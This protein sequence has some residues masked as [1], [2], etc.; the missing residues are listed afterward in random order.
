[1]TELFKIGSGPWEKLFEGN[2]QKYSLQLLSN[3]ESTILVAIFDSDNDK[4]RGVITEF[5]KI[6]SALG[7]IETFSETLPRELLVLTKHDSSKT[8]KFLAIGS[9]ASYT[10]W[11]EEKVMLETESQLS[12]LKTSSEMIKEV[13]KAYDLQLNELRKASSE[14]KEEFFTF[15]LL[16]PAMFTNYHLPPGL[17]QQSGK[18][19]Q[20]IQ[21]PGEIILGITR[22]GQLIEEPLGLF[23]R[24]AIF[25]GN[26]VSRKQAT[27]VL[28]EGCLLSN[29]PAVIFDQNHDFE[30][31]GFATKDYAR[32]KE[33]K[34]EIEPIGFPARKFTAISEVQ[35]NLSMT[36]PESLLEIF[37]INAGL[38]AGKIIISAMRSRPV[39]EMREIAESIKK[40][41]ITAELTAYHQL[42]AVR[43]LN[44]ML[45]RYPMLFDGK[46]DIEEI[47]KNWVRAI[48]RASVVDTSGLDQRQSL[49]LAAGIVKEM[50]EFYK[51]KG[52][53]K[54][55][56]SMVFIPEISAFSQL[57]KT[58][59]FKELA[60]SLIELKEYGVGFCTS[61][62]NKIDLDEEL[63]KSLEA[64]I[65]IVI[66]N[67]AGIN[68]LNKKQYRI[69][70]RPTISEFRPAGAK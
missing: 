65:G 52:Y 69:L 55:L 59:L 22:E 20:G 46:N 4:V 43:A 39:L 70:L 24:T 49:L 9:G 62:Q 2:F 27:Q 7:S 67:D 32:L 21:V 13:S 61:I 16:L 57:F 30:G 33:F 42:K 54:Q 8:S 44:L 15:P 31:I 47:S 5:Y 64:E 17:Q 10:E 63:A 36:S 56:K 14:V 26:D 1:M 48:G 6:Y 25:D 19:Q 60:R 38:P 11:S 41:E 58:G 3:P 50:L 23:S 18:E 34:L 51:Q 28:I 66:K 35:V 53:S 68:F 40:M 29:I 45:L 12:K 37:G